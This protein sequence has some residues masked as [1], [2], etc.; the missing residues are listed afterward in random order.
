MESALKKISRS[1]PKKVE[2]RYGLEKIIMAS[3]ISII[4]ALKHVQ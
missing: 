2:N 4:R 1:L 3:D